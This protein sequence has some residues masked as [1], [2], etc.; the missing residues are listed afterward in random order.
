MI[1]GEYEVPLRIAAILF[2]AIVLHGAIVFLNKKFLT[3]ISN[4]NRNHE[5][6][7]RRIATI[8][9][10]IMSTSSFIISLIAL[11]M[12]LKELHIDT[13]PIL[14]S[15][16]VLGLAIS[17]GAQALIKDVF[18]GL[19]ILIEDQY[20]EGDQVKL[21][22]FE[23]KVITITL[24]KTVLESEMG[25]HHIPNGSVKIVSAIEKINSKHPIT[26]NK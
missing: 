8:S 9:A 13:T 19:S 15:A 23:G 1:F 25:T 2:G 16:G 22:E 24:R 3:F 5:E 17:F 14:A 11:V 21:D 26:N 4:I 18:S 10:V 12:I 7:D 6:E 20:R